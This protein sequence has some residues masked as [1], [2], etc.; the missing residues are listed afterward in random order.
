MREL[1]N[2]QLDETEKM[3]LEMMRLSV[4]KELYQLLQLFRPDIHKL[5]DTSTQYELLDK[6]LQLFMP[7]DILERENTICLMV[8]GKLQTG[9]ACR[10]L[11]VLAYLGDTKFQCGVDFVPDG[12]LPMNRP[13]KMN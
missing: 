6:Q 7:K 4:R 1:Q 13:A 5:L 9:K 11:L 10:F 3:L 12:A 8:K 2:Y